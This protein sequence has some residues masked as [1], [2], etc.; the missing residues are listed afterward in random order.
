[1]TIAQ[2]VTRLS[3]KSTKRHLPVELIY[4]EACQNKK[5]AYHREKYLKSTYGHRYLRNRHSHYFTG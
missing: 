5:D 1:M 3:V 4:Y 2:P